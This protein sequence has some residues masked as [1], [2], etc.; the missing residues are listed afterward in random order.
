MTELRTLLEIAKAFDTPLLA[1]IAWVLW[2]VK[3]SEIPHLHNSIG[4]INERLARLEGAEAVR[5]RF[6]RS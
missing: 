2:R 6:R 1:V 4:E 3:S 5:A